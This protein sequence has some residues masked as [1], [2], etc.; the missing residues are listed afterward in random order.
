MLAHRANEG[1]KTRNCVTRPEQQFQLTEPKLFARRAE[2]AVSS[3]QFALEA[4]SPTAAAC[5]ARAVKR[6]HRLRASNWP[7]P[8]PAALADGPVAPHHLRSITQAPHLAT[9]RTP[10]PVAHD[11]DL[12]RPALPITGTIHGP[13]GLTPCAKS[14]D[15][16][17]P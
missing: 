6:L 7:L 11:C 3:T 8:N 16:V 12:R 15:N 17:E 5:A 14:G 1:L 13:A 4:D 2:F 9:V 10:P